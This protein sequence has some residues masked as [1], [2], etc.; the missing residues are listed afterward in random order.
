MP[1]GITGNKFYL[2]LYVYFYLYVFEIIM[3]V[4]EIGN[5]YID[6]LKTKNIFYL[7]P[8]TKS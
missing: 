2:Y 3:H 1:L 7:G 8:I 6:I 4:L 5:N